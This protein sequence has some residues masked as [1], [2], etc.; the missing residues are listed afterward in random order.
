MLNYFIPIVSEHSSDIIL[1]QY[2]SHFNVVNFF[3]GKNYDI[4]NDVLNDYSNY[5]VNIDNNYY[6]NHFSNNNFKLEWWQR[7]YYW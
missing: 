2:F 1:D 6:N 7:N 3:N 5:I 4:I